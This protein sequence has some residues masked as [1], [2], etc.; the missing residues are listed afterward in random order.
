[1]RHVIFTLENLLIVRRKNQRDHSPLKNPLY[2]WVWVQPCP[3]CSTSWTEHRLKLQRVISNTRT[4]T[5][6]E[7]HKSL[8]TGNHKTTSAHWDSGNQRL[9]PPW[10]R[11][12]RVSSSKWFKINLM[13]HRI[14]LG[15][16]VERTLLMCVLVSV[17][18]CEMR[19]NWTPI[20][21][22]T[23]TLS[24]FRLIS[25]DFIVMCAKMSPYLPH[26]FKSYMW[27]SRCSVHSSDR[28]GLRR[29]SDR[30]WILW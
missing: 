13:K 8:K 9:I 15:F 17:A 21:D 23:H 30:T 19:R 11:R 7:Q 20:I 24:W 14:S 3:S 28:L 1:M 26:L 4:V 5:T 25:W 6:R 29:D 12:I 27:A 16:L 22:H 18:V 2:K 10:I